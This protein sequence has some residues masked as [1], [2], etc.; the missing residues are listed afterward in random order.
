MQDGIRFIKANN[1]SYCFAYDS[2][3]NKE[4]VADNNNN[5]NNKNRTSKWNNITSFHTYYPHALHKI[6][7]QVKYEQVE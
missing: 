4:V 7:I 5:N 3:G 1:L 6:E 2:N